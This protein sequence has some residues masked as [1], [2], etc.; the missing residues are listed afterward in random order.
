MQGH[1]GR[2]KDGA[3]SP[4]FWTRL[5]HFRKIVCSLAM[6]SRW[7][8]VRELPPQLDL[9]HVPNMLNESSLDT[10]YSTPFLP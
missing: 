4:S 5:G 10:R 8:R 2:V 6:S 1:G 3:I 9:A 7:E